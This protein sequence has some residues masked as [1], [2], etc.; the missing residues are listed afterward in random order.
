[1]IRNCPGFRTNEMQKKKILVADDSASIR[2]FVEVVLEKAGYEILIAED[3]REALKL[4]FENDIDAVVADAL[5]PNLSGDELFRNLKTY[6]EKKNIPLIMLSGLAESTAR[7]AD[8][9]ADAFLMK[10]T[11]LKENLLSAVKRLV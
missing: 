3:G 10:D 6:P 5:M 2:R 8:S 11:G 9:V 1:M 7:P 4:A